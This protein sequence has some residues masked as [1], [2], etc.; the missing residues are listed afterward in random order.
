M[1]PSPPSQQDIKAVEAAHDLLFKRIMTSKN[2]KSMLCLCG[3][4]DAEWEVLK[5][6][7]DIVE[8]EYTHAT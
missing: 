8:Q 4:T 2:D 7:S 3:L 6:A 1:R 5:A